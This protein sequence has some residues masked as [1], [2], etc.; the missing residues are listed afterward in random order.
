M[1]LKPLLFIAGAAGA[2]AAVVKSRGGN[3]L[4]QVARQA[5]ASVRQAAASAPE[6]VQKIV[7][8]VTPTEA[9]G[10]QP[11]ERRFQAPAEGLA[12]TPVEA[13]GPPSADVP[14]REASS[15]ASDP[16]AGAGLN[17]PEHD[18]PG[19]AVIPDTTANDPL[20]QQQETAAAADAGAIG[21]NVD[22][23]V[24]DRPGGAADTAMR[25]VIEG[26]GDAEESFE[27]QEL[28]RGHRETEP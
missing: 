22:E 13:G 8:K 2:V 27:A 7:E 19:D 6:P 28:E 21:G 16:A 17:V 25:P 26:S 4:S 20:V 18:A 5:G 23:L 14:V 9:P 12:Q 24:S 1:K 11:S 10:E 3:R 15:V